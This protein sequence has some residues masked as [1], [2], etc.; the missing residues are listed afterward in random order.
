MLIIYWGNKL[1]LHPYDSIKGPRY[2]IDPVDNQHSVFDMS[3]EVPKWPYVSQSIV[4]GAI[5][6]LLN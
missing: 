6:D 2:E 4:S 3:H 5:C 1:Y